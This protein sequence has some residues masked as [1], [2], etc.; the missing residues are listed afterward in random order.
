MC[1]QLVQPIKISSQHPLVTK[2]LH[3]LTSSDISMLEA[4]EIESYTSSRCTSVRRSNMERS[5]QLAERCLHFGSRCKQLEYKT[6]LNLEGFFFTMQHCILK[7]SHNCFLSQSQMMNQRLR[8]LSD[9]KSDEEF[10]MLQKSVLRWNC[11]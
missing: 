10:I 1:V 9:K 2:R 8:N 3:V 7:I 11:R 6:L 4:A 5:A